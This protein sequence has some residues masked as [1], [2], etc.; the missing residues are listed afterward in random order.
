MSLA[1]V[2][3][4]RHF[5]NK[6]WNA[7][8]FSMMHLDQPYPELDTANM[9]LAD[10]WILSRL[11]NVTDEVTSSIDGY[12]FNDT[13]SSLYRFVWNEFCDWYL[14]A[15]KP[16]LYSKNGEAC[17]KASKAVLYRVLK[18]TLI[19]LHPVIP[20]VTEEIWGKI[21]GASGSIMNA[22]YPADRDDF[23]GLADSSVEKEM[24][25]VMGV[26]S[27]VRNIRGE[28]NISP[29][30]NLNAVIQSDNDV[31]RQMA[32][33]HKDMIMVLARLETFESGAVGEKPRSSATAIV[34][35][36]SL[37]VNLKGVL[38][39]DKEVERLE[40]SIAKLAKEV[41]SISKKLDNE[42]FMAKAPDDVVGKVRAQYQESKEKMDK[43]IENVK[44][45]KEA[46]V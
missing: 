28:M 5:I 14:E 7:A 20:F 8:R 43:Y 21:P 1:R 11:K 35:E 46:N 38:D 40:K 30:L 26:I 4:Y 22:V 12:H 27:G 15:S 33:K 36:A 19:L 25:F 17:M 37:F 32:L 29:S 13:A 34:G 39:F 2:D 3:G 6:L 45:I 10:K 31:E 42:S 18:D 23:A 44:K 9:G 16:A 24:D 41:D